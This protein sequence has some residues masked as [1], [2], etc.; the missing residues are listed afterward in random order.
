[1]S[2]VAGLTETSLHK[3]VIGQERSFPRPSLNNMHVGY[4]HAQVNVI[5]YGPTNPGSSNINRLQAIQNF[6]TRIVTSTRQ[7][8]S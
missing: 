3:I 8:R 7:V 1:M 6:V 4:D 2:Q 5:T